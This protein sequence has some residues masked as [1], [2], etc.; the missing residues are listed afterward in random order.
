MINIVEKGG[1]GFNFDMEGPGWW[2]SSELLIFQQ[3]DGKQE[4][5]G[6]DYKRELGGDI[7][8]IRNNYGKL[9]DSKKKRF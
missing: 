2:N 5:F 7:I 1:E 9:D 3:G 8:K 4:C 6:N